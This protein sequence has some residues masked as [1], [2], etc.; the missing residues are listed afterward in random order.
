MPTL[1]SVKQSIL[2]ECDEDH[3]GLWSVIRDVED[4]LPNR[5]EAG[6]RYQVLT[7]LHELLVARE[8]EAGFPTPDGRF[9]SLKATP[10]KFIARI[11]A[12]CPLRSRPPIAD[13]LR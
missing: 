5:D 2:T 8:I 6:V 9:R 13:E 4:S 3:V 10:E 1:E 7:M 11:Q 12:H